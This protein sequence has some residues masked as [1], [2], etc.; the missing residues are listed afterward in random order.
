MQGGLLSLTGHFSFQLLAFSP[1]TLRLTGT[2]VA[3][4]RSRIMDASD[5]FLSA[6]QSV[7]SSLLTPCRGLHL[8]TCSPP[9]APSQICSFICCYSDLRHV[10]LSCCSSAHHP[11]VAHHSGFYL[12]LGPQFL[13]LPGMQWL[14][15][16]RDASQLPSQEGFTSGLV[17]GPLS[18]RDSSGLAPGYTG[19]P[20]L[21]CTPSSH[22]MGL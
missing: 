5:A 1:T 21:L 17:H 13:R 20:L 7:C 19:C 9:A 10:H 18:V 14:A 2:T 8:Y 22:D 4:A 15:A 12:C 16:T 11:G 3:S 6:P